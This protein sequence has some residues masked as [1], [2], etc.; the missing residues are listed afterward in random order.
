V[1]A[2][3]QFMDQVLLFV[4]I[5]LRNII[6]PES[7]KGQANTPLPERRRIRDNVSGGFFDLIT[8]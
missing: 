6:R 1:I 2:A 5:C 4:V 8:V 7:K 3:Q